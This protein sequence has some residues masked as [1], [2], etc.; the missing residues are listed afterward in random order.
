MLA[1]F[2][3]DVIDLDPD[4][5]VIWGF[6]N[7]I[8]R[9]SPDQLK[10]AKER[11]KRSFEQMIEQAESHDIKVILA[12]EV[13]LREPA[14]IVNWVAGL[15][16][17]LRGKTSYQAMINKHVADLNLFV[18]QLAGS[19]NIVALDFHEVLSDSEGYRRR[20]FATEDGSHLTLSAYDALTAY[21][22]EAIPPACEAVTSIRPQGDSNPCC[23][24]ERAGVLG[25]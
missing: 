24:R 2:Q 18:R 12:T 6:I 22:E 13:S 16:G 7:D 3:E 4:A 20:E 15:M 8:F 10:S 1:R 25:L 21:A 23:R 17:R 9:A 5:V 19:K 14:G 11:I